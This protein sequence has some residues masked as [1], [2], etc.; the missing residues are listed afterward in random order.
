MK[1]VAV[2]LHALISFRFDTLN[3]NGMCESAANDHVIFCTHQN[4]G[5]TTQLI[6]RMQSIERIKLWKNTMK[7]VSFC[8]KVIVSVQMCARKEVVQ[9]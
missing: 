3:I 6:Y 1:N 8:I 5:F 4:K 7:V 2:Q 9:E